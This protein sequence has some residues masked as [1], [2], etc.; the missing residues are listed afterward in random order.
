MDD[1][2]QSAPPEYSQKQR[3]EV[4]QYIKDHPEIRE[5]IQKLMQAII[6][7]KPEKPLDFAR[8]YFQ[9]LKQ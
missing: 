4:K 7:S 6:E 8:E 9:N 1:S 5:I 2:Y 3:E